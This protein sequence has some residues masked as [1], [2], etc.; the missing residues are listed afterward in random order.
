MKICCA[1]GISKPF[2][3]YH[4]ASGRRDGRQTACKT[5]FKA[6]RKKYWSQNK[7]SEYRTHLS[8]VANNPTTRKEHRL[9][10]NLKLYNMTP[11]EFL[12][13]IESQGGCCKI[14][15]DV[16]PNQ[17]LSVDHDHVTGRVRGLL[18]RSCNLGLGMF[19]DNASFLV[20]ASKYLNNVSL[21]VSHNKN[22]DQ[23]GR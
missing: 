23:L 9:K 15:G 2:T 22:A 14:C 5:C 18:C 8:W 20:R 3:E 17:R 1:C 7:S 11:A 21:G 4:R 19:R 6:I 13:L 12:A 16:T 10:A